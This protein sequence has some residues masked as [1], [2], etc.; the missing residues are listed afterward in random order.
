MSIVK[1]F[2]LVVT[3]LVESRPI[4]SKL[5]MLSR[6]V[7]SRD[8]LSRQVESLVGLS[9]K[10]ESLVVLSRLVVSLFSVAVWSTMLESFS[11]SQLVQAGFIGMPSKNF[12]M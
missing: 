9:S 10:V 12:G 11:S 7:E 1:P 8:M 3:K 2:M 5:K 4:M 6:Q